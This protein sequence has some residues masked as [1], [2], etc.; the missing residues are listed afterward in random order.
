M[1]LII[2][3]GYTLNDFKATR[4]FIIFST[5]VQQ[6]VTK[7][8]ISISTRAQKVCLLAGDLFMLI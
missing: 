3:Q 7:I 6:Q 8:C 4:A 5:G 2:I 1:F